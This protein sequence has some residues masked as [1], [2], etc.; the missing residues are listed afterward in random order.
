MQKRME[1]KARGY[2]QNHHWKNT[3]KLNL[4]AVESSKPKVNFQTHALRTNAPNSVI[5]SIDF[6]VNIY[7]R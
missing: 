5:C 2:Q 4:L 6:F 1:I 3:N 7:K